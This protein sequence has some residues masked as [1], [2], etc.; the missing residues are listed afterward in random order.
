MLNEGCLILHPWQK[1]AFTALAL[2]LSVDTRIDIHD[3]GLKCMARAE[4][5]DVDVSI[6]S[7]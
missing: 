5:M 2:L 6:R 7:C 1:A 3:N 4:E